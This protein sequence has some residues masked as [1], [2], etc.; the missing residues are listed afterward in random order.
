MHKIGLIFLC[1][2]FKDGNGTACSGCKDTKL[3][4]S[5]F[6]NFRQLSP[7]FQYFRIFTSTYPNFPQLPAANPFL[8]LSIYL[9]SSSVLPF[10]EEEL[11]KN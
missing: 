7:T 9:S 5:T 10:C 11:R 4:P 2:W 3:F 6:P 1:K 8:F